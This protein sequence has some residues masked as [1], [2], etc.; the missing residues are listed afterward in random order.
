MKKLVVLGLLAALTVTG[1]GNKDVKDDLS[2]QNNDRDTIIFDDE[3]GKITFID[4]QEVLPELNADFLED[5][6]KD[7]LAASLTIM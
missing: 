7:E 2:G 4:S 1:C 5:I 6:K 3:F